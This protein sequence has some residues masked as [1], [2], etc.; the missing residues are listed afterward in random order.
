MVMIEIKQGSI[1]KEYT[2]PHPFG[3]A[4]YDAID[5]EI[6]SVFTAREIL[7]PDDVRGE[8][9]TLREAI[10]ARGWPLLDEVRGKVMF[11][12][13]NE[14]A[15]RD[16]YLEGHPSLRNRLLFV[17]V[18][19]THEAAAFMKINDPIGEFDRIQRA[20]KSG[21]LVRTRADSGTRESRHNETARRDKALASGAQFI[22]TDYPEPDR[23][24]SEYRVRFGNAIVARGNPVSG[25]LPWIPREFDPFGSSWRSPQGITGNSVR[26]P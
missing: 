3:P 26:E 4:E 25:K 9:A 19:Q 23:R 5:A 1:G 14:G 22:S 7:K 16:S 18:D 15:V 10:T 21:F 8:F 6:L 11:A 12:L 13:D 20:V 17:S 24:F 2:Q